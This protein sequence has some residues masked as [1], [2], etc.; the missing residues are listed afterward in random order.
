[1]SQAHIEPRALLRMLRGGEGNWQRHLPSD[2]HGGT[3]SICR[4]KQ[5]H[6]LSALQQASWWRR[7][8]MRWKNFGRVSRIHPFEAGVRT[9]SRGS[10]RTS[11]LRL[12]LEVV[13]D[14][15]NATE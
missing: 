13:G 11:L 6:G 1:M 8:I 7:D 3:A 15:W 9:A 2:R 10:G 5:D 12:L 4:G 14:C